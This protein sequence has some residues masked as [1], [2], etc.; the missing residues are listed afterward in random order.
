MPINIKFDLNRKIG[1][2][3]PANRFTIWKVFALIIIGLLIASTILVF[4]FVY[5]YSYTTLS[6]ANA[7]IVLNSSLGADVI[8]HKN[9]RLSQDTIKLKT[10]L[11]LPSEKIRNIFYYVDI[12]GIQPT[13]KSKKNN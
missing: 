11:P 1:Y 3:K 2:L 13:D 6:N 4:Y 12:S 8:D 9:F 7:I 10:E 5:Q